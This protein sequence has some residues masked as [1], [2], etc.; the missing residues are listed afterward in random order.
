ML[1][2]TA[3]S[4]AARRGQSRRGGPSLMLK[5]QA[6]GGGEVQQGPAFGSIAGRECSSISSNH[7]E[8]C[9]SLIQVHAGLDA[10]AFE[11]EDQIVHRDITCR[12]RRKGASASTASG[13]VEDV[14][15]GLDRRVGIGESGI[16]GV[17][18]MD[19][20]RA[21]GEFLARAYEHPFNLRRHGHPDRIGEIDFRRLRPRRTLRRARAPDQDRQHP[22]TDIRKKLRW[23]R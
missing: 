12:L 23:C 7:R 10:H 13:S 17:V 21:C 20:N 8:V 4:R 3:Q 16:A 2:S 18:D 11:H 19:A 15:A 9:T 22:Q 14:S 6:S 5:S 1:S